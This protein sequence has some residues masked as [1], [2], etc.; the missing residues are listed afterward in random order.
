[1]AHGDRA[2][3]GDPIA[4]VK[5]LI[6]ELDYDAWLKDHCSSL[7]SA[8]RRMANVWELVAWLQRLAEGEGKDRSLAEMVAHLTLMDILE[9]ADEEASGERVSLMT[10]HA[11]KGLEFP[12]VFMVGMEEDLLPHRESLTEGRLEEERRLAYVGIT[13]AQRTLTFTLAAK[14]KRF[15]D[16]VDCEPSRF[17]GELPAQDLAWEGVSV[18]VDPEK[19]KERGQAHLANLKGL[20]DRA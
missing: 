4:A 16:T 15:G 18:T 2:R 3:R 8:E 11:A 5:D 20:L 14:R 6:R 9:H 7:K 1:V 19:R 17:L 10:L 12:H 13:R